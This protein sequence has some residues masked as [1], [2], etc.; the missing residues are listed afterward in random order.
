MTNP[1]IT[2]IVPVYNVEP[3]LKKCVDS[4]ICQTYKN[5]EIIL[6]NDGSPDN[7]GQICDEYEKKDMRIKVI[8]KENGGL[9]SARNAGID[10]ATG[11]YISFID[12]DDYINC[13]MY[14]YM[15][16]CADVH[17]NKI[18]VCSYI[19]IKHNK[20][21]FFGCSQNEVYTKNQALEF[22]F[23]GG[24]INNFAWNK[25]YPKH[26]FTNV[27][28]PLG[29]K[30]EDINT[31]YKTFEQSE[32]MVC[33]SKAFYNY[34][35]NEASITGKKSILNEID[36][37]INAIERYYDVAKRLP[38]FKGVLLKS[39][40][41]TFCQTVYVSAQNS[42]S[43]QKSARQ[44]REVLTGFITE[45]TA[46]ISAHLGIT[47]KIALKLISKNT[48][49]LDYLCCTVIVCKKFAKKIRR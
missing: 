9:S 19:L 25:L 38:Q 40:F 35:Y 34:I 4:I 17:T 32:G 28:Y 12:S 2:V 20:N 11:D 33:V 1:K 8:H 24:W 27:R 37:C 7:C 21:T 10:I 14:E 47:D 44:N 16:Q 30:F 29:R 43:A 45:N 6:V 46:D 3:Y 49:V 48:L 41:T 15:I 13:K 22:L 26:T 39:L 18:I 31:T 23:S 5:L 42:L 36:A